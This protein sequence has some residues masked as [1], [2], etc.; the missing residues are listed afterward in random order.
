MKKG[1]VVFLIVQLLALVFFVGFFITSVAT[2]NIVPT[3]TLG[4]SFISVGFLISTTWI[5]T[6]IYKARD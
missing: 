2:N 1:L 6:T 3:L 4:C 5:F